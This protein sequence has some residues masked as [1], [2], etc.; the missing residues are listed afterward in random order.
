MPTL[1]K[2][3]AALLMLLLLNLNLTGCATNS[4]L[5][6]QPARILAPPPELME[7]EGPERD[8]LGASVRHLVSDWQAK[9]DRLEGRS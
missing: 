8:L 6:V 5:V 2:S 3:A 9:L 7:P 1:S 4:P